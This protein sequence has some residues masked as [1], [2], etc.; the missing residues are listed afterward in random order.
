MRPKPEEQPVISHV[1]GRLG[2]MKVVLVDIL[3]VILLFLFYFSLW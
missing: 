3:V 2:L 1:K